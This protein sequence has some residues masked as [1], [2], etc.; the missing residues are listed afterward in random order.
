ML[1]WL[2]IYW[3]VSINSTLNIGVRHLL[4]TFPLAILLVSGQISRIIE[5]AKTKSKNALIGSG[6]ILAG[7]LG[8]FVSENLRIFP[9][10]LSYF[11]QA[12][13]G[14]SGGYKYVVDSNVDWGQDLVRFSN[15]VKE[16]N[17]PRVEFDY[18]GWAD[19]YYYLKDRYIWMS[20]TKYT[21]ANDFRTR[22][23]SDGWLAVSATFLQGSQGSPDQPKP[24]NYLWL[25]S[26]QPL[27]VIGNSIFV[28]K[29]K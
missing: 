28:Y 17:I 21:D 4:P 9:Y 16:N 3:G 25:N 11:N 19:P 2:F 14:P 24:V 8:W 27:T 10:Y 7:L 26:Y 12:V 29:I 20:A 15:W 18:F 5:M 23:Q 22:N 1:L 6:L 13:G